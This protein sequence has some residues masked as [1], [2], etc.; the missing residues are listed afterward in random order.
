M[1]LSC[2]KKKKKRD[3]DLSGGRKMWNE[4][5]PPPM[6]PWMGYGNS[7]HFTSVNVRE[8]NIN[9]FLNWQLNIW[10]GTVSL[11]SWQ[12]F[13][14]HVYPKGVLP[15]GRW[16]YITEKAE[17][18]RCLN[19]SL[20][21]SNSLHISYENSMVTPKGLNQYC[22][23]CFNWILTAALRFLGFKMWNQNM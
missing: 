17:R 6:V 5:P 1:E 12:R 2:Q 11:L 18:D 19:R 9:T 14:F 23:E 7:I 3:L 22:V 10:N 20:F 21:Q 15:W 4:E 13:S 16:K 8:N